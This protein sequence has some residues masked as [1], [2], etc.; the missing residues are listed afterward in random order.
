MRLRR[1]FLGLSIAAVIALS[2]CSSDAPKTIQTRPVRATLPEN[3]CDG[4]TDEYGA[5]LARVSR[6]LDKERVGLAERVVAAA[7]QP[8]DA[9]PPSAR[10]LPNLKNEWRQSESAFVTY[11]TRTCEAVNIASF[12]GSWAGIEA[13]ACAIRLTRER[14]AFLR[15]ALEAKG[16]Y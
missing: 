13:T 10:P 14:I 9:V 4:A 11:L 12:G 1:S 7:V 6:Q 8:D 16:R 3:R 15:I 5:C 2:G